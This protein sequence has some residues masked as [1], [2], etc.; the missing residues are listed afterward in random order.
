MDVL[1]FYIEHLN[2]MY[3]NKT[4]TNLIKDKVI[5]GKID[6]F[7]VVGKKYLKTKTEH[8]Q[9]IS[10]ARIPKLYFFVIDKLIFM[11]KI[12]FT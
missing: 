10:K 9:N 8:K 2:P 12:Y 1:G 7:C 11:D 5:F 3:Q 4:R 6:F